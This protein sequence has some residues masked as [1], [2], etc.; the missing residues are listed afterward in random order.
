MEI[1]PRFYLVGFHVASRIYP[2]LPV[3]VHLILFVLITEG[4]SHPRQWRLPPEHPAL[5]V[6]IVYVDLS[7]LFLRVLV[8][9][10][11]SFICP[12]GPSAYLVSHQYMKPSTTLPRFR[13]VRLDTKMLM[14]EELHLLLFTLNVSLLRVLPYICCKSVYPWPM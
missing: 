1:P 9:G 13:I 3:Y 10:V 6:Y 2:T 8:Q 5:C 12:S 4:W 14:K 11:S 7:G